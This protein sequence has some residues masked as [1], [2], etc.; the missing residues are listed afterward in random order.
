MNN[1]K[2]IKT[3]R[4]LALEVLI[5]V[6]KEKSYSN[7]QLNQS[8]QKIDLSRAD[9]SLATE[10]IYGTI[11]RLNTIDWILQPFLKT[12]I[13]KLD[14]WVKN[15]LR[16]SIYQIWYLDRVPD[17]AT[18]NEAVNIAKI[19]GHKGITG[20]VN[21]VL[22][23]IIRNK[24]S[25]SFPEN[26]NQTARIALEH[27]HPEWVVQHFVKDFGIDQAEEICRVNNLPPFHSIRVNT[28][29]ISREE[30]IDHLKKELGEEV[31]INPSKLSKQGIRI[32]GGG[33]LAHTDWYKNGY[34][35]VQ[36][37]SSM[38][39]ADVLNAMP[40]MT[41]LDAAA[42]PGGKT[43]HI[44]EKMN[45]KGRIIAVDLHKH[46][47]KLIE[48]Q[49]KRL[50]LHIIDTFNSDARNIKDHYGQ[51][52]DRILLD[53]PCSGL[54][55]IRR[56]PDLKWSKTEADIHKLQHIQG[57]ILE[58]VSTLL[59]PGGVLVYSTCTLVQEENEQLIKSF[60]NRHQEFKLD[61]SLPSLLSQELKEKVDASDGMIQ[62]LPQHFHTDGFFISRLVKRNLL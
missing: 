21:G 12:K 16:I 39:V 3:A 30:M 13:N 10:I 59:K 24:D 47:I 50:D 23:N 51:I 33:N 38:L 14:N 28:L 60:I 2:K 44:A 32:K 41:V 42:A 58:A 20:M 25:I 49:Q 34:I 35:S 62:I 56:K 57:E 53:V 45:D 22:R 27:S 6:D 1:M 4:D 15:L 18:V 40:D 37:E 26:L 46:K 9:I 52:F 43:T 36:D 17:H 5:K 54:G 29:K 31:E 55:V 19:R 48:E 11:Q 61:T 8:L 7:L